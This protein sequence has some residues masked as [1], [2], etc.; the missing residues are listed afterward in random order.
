LKNL[1]V[2]VGRLN[3][4]GAKVIFAT[5]TPIQDDP[6]KKKNPAIAV[7]ERNQAAIEVMKKTR[8]P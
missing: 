6:T 2:I 1:E 4:T 3:A 7:V 8:C 5:T